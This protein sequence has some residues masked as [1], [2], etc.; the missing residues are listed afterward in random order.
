MIEVKTFKY[1]GFVFNC[2]G[3]Y[4]EHVRKL[5]KKGRIAAKRV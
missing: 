1:L 2:K 5:S 4:E 3:N